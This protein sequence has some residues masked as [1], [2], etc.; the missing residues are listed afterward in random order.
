MSRITLANILLANTL[1]EKE[2]AKKAHAEDLAK[3]PSDLEQITEFLKQCTNGQGDPILKCDEMGDLVDG[4][5][6]VKKS[7]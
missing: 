7:H 6:V 3:R 1:E 4:H 2:A 5:V